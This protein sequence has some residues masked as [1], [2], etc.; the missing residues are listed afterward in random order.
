MLAFARAFLQCSD[1]RAQQ[2]LESAHQRT[3]ACVRNVGYRIVE[4]NEHE[5]LARHHH[6]KS[7]RQLK[8]ASRRLSSADRSALTTEE[9]ERVDRLESTVARHSDLLRRLDRRTETLETAV[10]AKADAAATEDRLSRIEDLLRRDG[11]S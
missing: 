6:K 10:D 4:A 1:D 5:G 7:R 2:E 9:A 11:K 8:K 3:L